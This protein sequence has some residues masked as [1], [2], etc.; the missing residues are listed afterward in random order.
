MA[1]HRVNPILGNYRPILSLMSRRVR[2]VESGLVIAVAHFWALKPVGRRKSHE[3]A[4]IHKNRP[5]AG[6][7]T[8]LSAGCGDGAAAPT[9]GRSTTGRTGECTAASLRRGPRRNA[10]GGRD[11]QRGGQAEGTRHQS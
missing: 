10:V 1:P 5:G 6:S 7:G 8:A 3:S 2:S 9:V 4:T 11:R